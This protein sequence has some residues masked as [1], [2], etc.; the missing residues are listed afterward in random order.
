MSRGF[1]VNVP[2]GWLRAMALPASFRDT[3]DVKGASAGFAITPTGVSITA[4]RIWYGAN[5]TVRKAKRKA[6]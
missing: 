3:V 2:T 4:T 1:K 5:V 6:P